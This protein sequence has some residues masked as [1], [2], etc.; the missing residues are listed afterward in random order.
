[1]P[2]F[3][4]DIHRNK[5]DKIDREIA[6]LL[7]R[8]FEISRDINQVKKKTGIKIYQ[9]GRERAVLNNVFKVIRKQPYK[10]M[11]ERI[12]RQIMTESRKIQR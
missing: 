1:M 3:K 12:Y 6:S 9:P 11:V 10:C 4:L 7:M 8:R 2:E 5:I